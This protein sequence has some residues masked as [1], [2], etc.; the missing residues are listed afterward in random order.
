MSSF[1]T[2][3]F[4]EELGISP[5]KTD[6]VSPVTGEVVKRSAPTSLKDSF[7]IVSKNLQKHYDS[8]P[9]TVV[10]DYDDEDYD[11]DMPVKQEK[12]LTYFYGEAVCKVS[13]DYLLQYL[14]E[15]V[16]DYAP[17]TLYIDRVDTTISYG[18]VTINGERKE[19]GRFEISN[20]GVLH[21]IYEL[22][23]VRFADSFKEQVTMGMT[24]W[25]LAPFISD[26][27]EV[28]ISS[29]RISDLEWIRQEKE[30]IQETK[31]QNKGLLV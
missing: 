27:T 18:V 12:E 23:R 26:E 13:T 3:A 11:Y 6:Y 28:T 22:I 7:A 20:D 8:K 21:A 2:N 19:T 1:D 29:N 15:Q 30:T 10:T 14:E 25:T 4:L 5:I 17:K 31:R 9:K 24:G 16:K